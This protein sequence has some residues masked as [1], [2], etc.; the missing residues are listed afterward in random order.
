MIFKK[1]RRAGGDFSTLMKT[2]ASD[3]AIGNQYFIRYD[4]YRSIYN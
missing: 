4:K 3:K 2:N 1:F